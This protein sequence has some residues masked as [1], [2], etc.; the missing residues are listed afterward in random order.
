MVKFV[1]KTDKGQ[2][3]IGFGLSRK[4]IE[5]LQKNQPIMIDMA[6]LLGFG[7]SD[8]RVAIFYGETEEKMQKTLEKHMG[9]AT[10]IIDKKRGVEN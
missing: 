7:Y 10:I 1:M 9:D 8:L 6:T 2:N 5:L 4:N 3:L